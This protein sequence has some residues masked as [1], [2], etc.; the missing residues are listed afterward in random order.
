[1][2]IYAKIKP[3]SVNN[4]WRGQRFK[5]PEYKAYEQELLYKLPMALSMPI[6]PYA[7]HF[8]LGLSSP[9]ADYDNCI[10]PLQDILQKKYG[11]DD[12]D[13]VFASIKK[14]KVKKGEEFFKVNLETFKE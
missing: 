6:K 10:K 4:C 12:K 13:I 8:D 7:I 2:Q 5:T 3:I 9:L 11:F 14:I 1:M